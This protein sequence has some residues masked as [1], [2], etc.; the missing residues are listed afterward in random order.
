MSITSV[1]GRG[2]LP[3]RAHLLQEMKLEIPVRFSAEV[4]EAPAIFVRGR[5]ANVR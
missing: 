1:E 2:E 3:E 4:K 5:I